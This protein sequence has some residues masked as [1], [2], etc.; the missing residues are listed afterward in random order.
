VAPFNVSLWDPGTD[1]IGKLG[2]QPALRIPSSPFEYAFSYR[3]PPLLKREFAEKLGFNEE[4]V[5]LLTPSG[6]AANL[7]ALNLLRQRGVQRL[8]VILPAYFQVPI[9]AQGIGFDVACEYALEGGMGWTVADLSTVDPQLDAVWITHPI[10]GVGDT[11][12]ADARRSLLAFMDAGGLVAADECLCMVGT[13][14][15]R[16][17][18]HHPGFIGSYSPHKSVC[19]N[20][21]KLGAVV[22][23]AQHLAVLENLSDIWAGPLT[24]MSLADAEHFLSSNFDLMQAAVEARLS[25]SQL[26]VKSVAE[27]FGCTLQGSTGPYRSLRVTGVSRELELSLDY[28]SK[29]IHETGT[30]FIPSFVNLGTPQAPFSFRVNLAR[31]GVAMNAALNRLLAAIRQG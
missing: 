22:T 29:L 20:G 9:A 12:S 14:I 10:Y 11:F 16:Q 30:S 26:A 7:V 28:V 6:T 5:V 19:M 21:V 23:D 15:C 18:G 3:A 1:F 31:W 25:S 17:L 24:R 2:V 27:R 8:R 13:E 4:R